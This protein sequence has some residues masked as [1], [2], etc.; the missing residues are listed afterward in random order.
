MQILAVT[1][2]FGGNEE[3]QAAFF[4][5]LRRGTGG[6]VTKA[7]FDRISFASSML[8]GRRAGEQVRLLSHGGGLGVVVSHVVTMCDSAAL[9]DGGDRVA[10]LAITARPFH[11]SRVAAAAA[12]L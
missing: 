1:L 10:A 7:L 9:R 8:R 5:E 11:P 4:A 12:A 6:S 2:L 3:V